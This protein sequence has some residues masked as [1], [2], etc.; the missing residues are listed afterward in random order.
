MGHT[1]LSR[2][3]P[4]VPT[5]GS[6][7]HSSRARPPSPVM[8]SRAGRSLSKAW[9]TNVCF[10]CACPREFL[11]VRVE[12]QV[13]PNYVLNV[14]FSSKELT[15][16]NGVFSSHYGFSW[17]AVYPGL[18]CA[19]TQ[20]TWLHSAWALP[21]RLGGDTRASGPPLTVSLGLDTLAGWSSPMGACPPP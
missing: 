17:P 11:I 4:L 9:E 20:A 21:L 7:Q 8:G 16:V 10:A 13:G 18:P 19:R 14:R 15:F 5:P 6:G 12:D 1:A 3:H 2:C